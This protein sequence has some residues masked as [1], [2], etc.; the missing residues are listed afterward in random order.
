MPNMRDASPMAPNHEINV[1]PMLDVLL[2]LL[3]IFMAAIPSMRAIDVQ[4]PDR[5]RT[6]ASTSPAIV[7]ELGADG[8]ASINQSPIARGE[9]ATRLRAIYARRPEKVLFVK[10]DRRLR[11]DAVVDAMDVARGAGVDVIGWP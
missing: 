9:L 1:T 8:S 4:L 10:A 7:L 2:V 11:Y 3:I 6:S 5:Q